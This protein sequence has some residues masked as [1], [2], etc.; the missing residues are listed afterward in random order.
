MSYHFVVNNVDG[1]ARQLA[2]ELLR[3]GQD[4]SVGRVGKIQELR[5]VVYDIRNPR[6]VWLSFPTLKQSKLWA[7]SEVMTE[8]LG[9]NPPLTEFYTKS[10]KTKEFME[11]F[12]KGDGRAN[13]T[14]GERWHN[15]QAFQRVLKR[16]EQ[17]RYSRQALMNI[18]DSSLDLDTA[19]FNVPCTIIHQF[20]IRKDIVDGKDRL[21]LTVFMRSNDFFKGFKYDTFLNSFILQAFAG[22]TG[23]EV[24][25]LTFFVGSL[26][27]YEAD[28]PTLK[29]LVEHDL[30]RTSAYE[31]DEPSPIPFSLSFKEL[32]RQLWGVKDLEVR[33]RYTGKV[34]DDELMLLHPYFQDW[35]R[36]YVEFNNKNR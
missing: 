22:F 28:I 6:E 3:H 7:Y 15:N 21:H 27:V 30:V 8:F 34:Y 9:L 33:S 17:D 5:N 4:V 1:I 23:C 13:Y 26:H 2:M 19:E 24:G 12:H 11:T 31:L 35:A 20:L 32:Y 18:W 36:A 14:Y 25:T 10:E 16:L 29:T